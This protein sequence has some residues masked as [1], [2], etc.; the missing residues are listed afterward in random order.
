MTERRSWWARLGRNRAAVE[1]TPPL[2]VQH[3]RVE[4]VLQVPV[5]RSMPA[6]SSLSQPQSWLMGMLGAMPSATGI[7][8]TP[9]TALQAAAVYGCVKCRS[10]DLAKLPIVMR[11]ERADGQGWDK[12]TKHPLRR[13]FRRPNR[14]MTASDFISYVV[15]S[16]DL[17]GNAYIA[18]ARGPDGSPRSLIPLSPDRVSVLLSPNGTLFYNVHH[19]A[20]GTGLTLHQDDV[21]HVRGL[22]L[23]GYMGISPIAAGQDAIGLALATQQHGAALFRQ[24]AQISGVL[25]IAGSLSPE[26]AKRLGQSWQDTYGGVANAAKI[27]VL[28]EGAKFEKIA[29]TNEQAQYL[30]TRGFQVLDICRIFRTPPH[31]VM[32]LSRATF[33]NIEEQNQSYID[34]ALLPTAVRIEQALEDK[35][36]FEDE[37]DIELDFDFD[38]LLRGNMKTRFETYQIGLLNGVWNRNEVRAKERENPVPGGEI[39]R[40]PLNTV[41][42]SISPDGAPTPPGTDAPTKPDANAPAEPKPGEGSEDAEDEKAKRRR[43]RRE[44]EDNA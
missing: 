5:T 33:S 27:A 44:A 15:I 39:Y 34:E 43:Q 16:L 37:D 40:V 10:E 19:P 23:D 22:S 7:P 38:A 14:W 8:V 28:E 2:T 4:P 29:L 18:V 24:G 31:K 25:S 35:L 32:D 12:L 41:D 17:R 20:L 13:L 6:D 26:A 1:P 3:P 36:L 21:V 11:R 30:E 42:A 9:L